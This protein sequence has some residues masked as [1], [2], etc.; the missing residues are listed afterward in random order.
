MKVK[1]GSVL[2]PEALGVAKG[3]REQGYALMCVAFAQSDLVVETTDP[4]EVYEMQFGKY[5]GEEAGQPIV[6]DDFAF[7]LADMD[8]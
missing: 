7:E 2:Q 4:D 6:R 3:L 1:S 5:F 8:E